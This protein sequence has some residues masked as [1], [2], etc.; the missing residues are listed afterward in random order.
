[1]SEARRATTPEVITVHRA[2]AK[3]SKVASPSDG[4]ASMNVR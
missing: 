2:D 3:F 1:M 4:L